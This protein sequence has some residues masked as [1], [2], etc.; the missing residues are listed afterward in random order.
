MINQ[1]PPGL[2]QLV[3]GGGG[4]SSQGGR[5]GGASPSSASASRR[6]PAGA[7]ATVNCTACKT[8]LIVPKGHL[9]FQCQQCNAIIS[10]KAPGEWECEVCGCQV[11]CD[12]SKCRFCGHKRGSQKSVFAKRAATDRTEAMDAL[13][14]QT[15]RM[16]KTEFMPIGIAI[17]VERYAGGSARG[18][19]GGA[20]LAAV[21]PLPGAAV[22]AAAA[23][24]ATRIYWALRIESDCRMRWQRVGPRFCEQRDAA[25]RMPLHRLHAE[26]SMAASTATHRYLSFP[27]QP[28]LSVDQLKTACAALGVSMR[29]AIEKS[30]LFDLLYGPRQPLLPLREA[31]A[32]VVITPIADESDYF[33]V[34]ASADASAAALPPLPPTAA[35]SRDAASP[36]AG[37]TAAAGD[38]DVDNTA[39]ASA[40]LAE[41]D[42]D[43]A[44]D[45][46]SSSGTIAAVEETQKAVN[47]DAALSG[48]DPEKAGPDGDGTA[49]AA[50]AAA[51]A[52]AATVLNASAAAAALPTLPALPLRC[53]GAVGEL[54]A[55]PASV[56]TAQLREADAMYLT[57]LP[58]YAELLAEAT[59][60]Y[61]AEEGARLCLMLL[62][63]HVRIQRQLFRISGPQLW[64][65]QIVEE[66]G[67]LERMTWQ[68]ADASEVHLPTRRKTLQACGGSGVQVQQQL[69]SIMVQ[70]LQE[71]VRWFRQHC[72]RLKVPWEEG[73]IVIKVR[74]EKLLQDAFV[75]VQKMC[76]GS[77]AGSVPCD[78][79]KIWRFVFE[80]EPAM[81][82]G[83]VAREF[84][85]EVTNRLFNVDFG[86]FQLGANDELAYTI[87][88]A[89]SIANELSTEYFRF[90]GRFIGKAL[91]DGQLCPGAHLIHPM[92]KM[93]LAWPIASGDL[94]DIDR[95]LARNLQELRTL[96]PDELEDQCLD[97]TVSESE[98]GVARIVELKSG[99]G[100]IEVCAENL[101]E[102][103]ELRLRHIMVERVSDQLA[104][105]LLG[106]YEVVPLALLC[107]FTTYEL[108]LLICGLP[109]IDVT[110]WRSHTVYR[111][112][113]CVFV[114]PWHCGD[115]GRAAYLSLP[116]ADSVPAACSLSYL[117]C[118][119]CSC[120]F[121]SL[122]ARSRRRRRPIRWWRGFGAR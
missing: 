24:S 31:A 89:S 91:F 119:P 19:G 44:A 111:G 20:D 102:Y 104:Q 39:S 66:F 68:R 26:K 48:E 122:Q 33:Q 61:S 40:D 115:P 90:A 107:V 94:G 81:D 64:V 29:G 120:S 3:P 79:Y 25:W 93:I 9:K 62:M 60:L 103:L 36:D 54:L 117:S 97:F 12:V 7:P 51:A 110:D 27:S 67:S 56:L 52:A 121:R 47:T 63:L 84:F 11:A 43:V 77:D 98:F 101:D 100:E 5:R 18:G 57:H 96:D 75:A 105:F 59:E 45:E 116:L 82:A 85:S 92:Y 88:P 34:D 112:A 113:C 16:E 108:E 58:E 22:A 2:A 65:R 8:K 71:K 49:V 32:D 80:D 70:P 6:Q 15:I 13:R 95:E 76:L 69:T 38:P 23:A 118:F 53:G 17:G 74:R 14:A 83:G 35:A 10:L 72:A 21:P 99:G 87:N 42:G 86:L 106:V 50:A 114:V 41:A 4:A 30:D 78:F 109:F 46:E 55:L 28:A 1:R 73:H 37:A